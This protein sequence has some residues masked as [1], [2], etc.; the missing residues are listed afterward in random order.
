MHFISCGTLQQLCRKDSSRLL[1]W[2]CAGLAY[3]QTQVRNNKHTLICIKFCTSV[4]D[5]QK[6]NSL[7]KALDF[8]A[9][10]FG[11]HVW[12]YT[13]FELFWQGYQSTP[14]KLYC[15]LVMLFW[16][17]PPRGGVSPWRCLLP[18]TLHTGLP[19]LTQ[20]TPRK[21][22]TKA[23]NQTFYRTRL[24]LGPWGAVCEDIE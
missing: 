5:K 21:H 7:I 2:T 15:A 17:S 6:L 9:I 11:N 18:T 19:R 20:A 14:C 23:L 10:L 3:Q 22:L 8:V 1:D 4:L 24:F 16:R 12:F 13:S